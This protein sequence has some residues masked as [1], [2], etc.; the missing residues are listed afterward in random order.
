MIADLDYLH[1]THKFQNN[2]HNKYAKPLSYVFDK[3]VRLNNK[4]IK[5]K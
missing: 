5:T 4:N 2:S 1:H 3:K